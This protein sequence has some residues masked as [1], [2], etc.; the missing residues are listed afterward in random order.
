[1][2]LLLLALVATGCGRYGFAP[3]PDAIRDAPPTYRDVVLGD[4]PSAYWRLG[5]SG[6]VAVDELGAND[7]TYSGA[8]GFGIA[9]AIAGDANTAVA[10]DGTSCRVTLPD[11]FDFTGDQAFSIEAWVTGE[12]DGTF[13]FVFATET[14]GAQNPIDGYGLLM[15][16]AGLELERVV[17][18]TNKESPTGPITATFSHVVGVYDG[19]SL[20][21]YID[22]QLVG[23]V[24]D[25][26]VANPTDT[27]TIIGSSSTGNF[28]LGSIDEV[29]VYPFA[30][31][32]A[33]V[34]AHHAKGTA[35]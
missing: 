7:G 27:S 30:L 25:T 2:R 18:M 9:G 15:Q 14:R 32:A 31:S 34:A 24:A 33:Q 17:T 13:R 12:L 22:G 11:A 29:A 16:P 3:G 19:G 5:D 35:L 21:L 28:F 10:F 26:R 8:C 4:G 23:A 1:M 20:L 6:G